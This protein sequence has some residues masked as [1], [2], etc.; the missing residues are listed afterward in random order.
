MASD[1]QI[2]GTNWCG[3]TYEVRR[4]LTVGQFEYDYFNIDDDE[5]ADEFVLTANQGHRRF[6][7]V[8]VEDRVLIAPTIA[9]LRCVLHEHGMRPSRVPAFARRHRWQL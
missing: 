3:V 9:K 2:Y 1:I 4:F 8:V 6:P 5:I 7:I